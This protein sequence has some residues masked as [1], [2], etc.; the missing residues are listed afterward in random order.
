MSIASEITRINN[1]I[2]AAYTSCNAKGATMPVTQNSANLADCIDSIS[3]GG[4][5][6]ITAT[7]NT[8]SSISVGDKVWICKDTGNA[9][10]YLRTFTYAT[11]YS[12]TGFAKTSGANGANIDVETVFPSTVTITLET[13]TDDAYLNVR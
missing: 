12:Y 10:L 2:A 13:T 9:T 8:G 6:T 5:D 3:G 11:Q 4:G 1:N 7:N